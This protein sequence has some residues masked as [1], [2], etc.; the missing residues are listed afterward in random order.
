MKIYKEIYDLDDFE[1]WG[2]AEDTM[3]DLSDE[4][5]QAIFES[6]EET[7]PDGLTETELNDILAYDDDWIRDIVG[8]DYSNYDSIEDMEEKQTEYIVELLKG[9]F[10][11]YDEDEIETFAEGIVES[12]DY[13]D[14][15]DEQ[16]ERGF[17]DEYGE[18][19]A[20][21]VLDNEISGYDDQKESFIENDWDYYATDEKNVEAFR[22]YLKED[23]EYQQ[24]LKESWEEIEEDGKRDERT[25]N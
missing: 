13:D 15:D 8:Y 20:I 19:H 14:Y 24:D 17:I 7:Y 6:I 18:D 3:R 23:E 11:D 10:P 5:K 4:D 21:F 12:G 25:E 1:F 16:L 2:P 9:V 22:E